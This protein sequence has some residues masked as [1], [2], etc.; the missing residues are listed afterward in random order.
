MSEGRDKQLL[1]G[2]EMPQPK[3]VRGLAG[4]FLRILGLWL[5]GYA[6]FGKG[7]AYIGIPPIY[8]DSFLMAIGVLYLFLQPRWV[9]L[10]KDLSFTLLLLFMVWG[11]ARTL[12]YIPIF[13]LDAIRD[14]V[15]WSYALVAFVLGYLTWKFPLEDWVLPWYIRAMGWLPFWVPIALGVRWLFGE[16]L[17]RLPWGPE[18]GVPVVHVK[19][20]DAAVHLAG[21]LAFWLLIQP[22]LGNPGVGKRLFWFG[23]LV[24]FITVAAMNRG[25]FLSIVFVAFILAF[26]VNV[27]R[28]IRVAMIIIGFAVALALLDIEVDVGSERKISFD[29]LI[30]NMASI[31]TEIEGFSGEGSKWWRLMWWSEILNYTVFGPYFWT[32]KG[33]GIN[34]ADDDGFQVTSDG[35]LRSP[36]NG[37]LTIL[38]RA[39]V[40]GFALWVL[41][42]TLLLGRLWLIYWRWRS[43]GERF[44]AGLRLWTFSYL[45]AGIVNGAFD[46]YLEGP[47]GGIWFWAI[48]GFG[49]GLLLKEG[50]LIPGESGLGTYSLPTARR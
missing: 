3:L 15:I 18:G 48:V 1:K 38:A 11:A 31:F 5:L 49:I 16:V 8:V 33:F 45:L 36:H 28:W 40:P 22:Y 2:R 47:Q 39:G 34:L 10:S 24:S 14:S 20:G 19:A 42:F 30:T 17:P 6:Y 26:H 27:L 37:H 46:V 4:I 25:G 50:R 9:L 23:W 43:R 29:Q 7:F 35:S 41:F 12:P 32:G 21:L 44:Q 13:G